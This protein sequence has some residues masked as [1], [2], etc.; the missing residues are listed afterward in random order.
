MQCKTEFKQI[1][2]WQRFCS[3]KC[4]N[5]YHNNEGGLPL[6]PALR[7]WLQDLAN[8]H[9]TTLNEMACRILDKARNPDGQPMD[10]I[11]GSPKK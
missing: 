10:D 4:R 5:T 6:T 2:P 11:Y 3:D 9:G 1:R 7:A 8:V